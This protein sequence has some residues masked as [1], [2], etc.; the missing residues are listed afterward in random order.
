MDDLVQQAIRKWP[1]VPACFGWLGLDSRGQW[2]LRDDA[3]QALGAFPL[4]KGDLLVHGKLLAF[5]CRNYAADAQGQ[6][7]FQN[8]PQRVYV[9]IECTP[10]IWRLQTDRQVQTQTG[11]ITRADEC[12]TDAEGRVYF[13]SK[14]GFGLLHSNDVPQLADAIERGEWSP[15][16]VDAAQMPA[17]FGFVRSPAA[18]T[19]R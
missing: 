13:A 7:Y 15:R 1:N 18:L 12:L 2:F 16:A 17:Q 8:G 6:W 11:R 14:I 10:W 5:I 3:V 9:E 19:S 4:N